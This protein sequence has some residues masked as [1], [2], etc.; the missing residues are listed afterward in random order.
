[1]TVQ[2][3]S[4]HAYFLPG[5]NLFPNWPESRSSEVSALLAVTLVVLLAPKLFGLGLALADRTIRT[6]FGGAGALLC[7]AAAELAF[8]VLLAPVMMYCHSRFVVEILLG[9]SVGWSTQPRDDRGIGLREAAARFALPTIFGLAWSAALL[10]VAP[11]YFVWFLPV[12]AGLVLSIPIAILSG[13][14]APGRAAARAGLFLTPE[15][16][17][18]PDL[19]RRLDAAL[20]HQPVLADAADVQRLTEALPA[21]SPQ[22]MPTQSL[23]PFWR[24]R[25]NVRIGGGR[26][27]AT[28]HA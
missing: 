24:N 3:L 1:V 19:L 8:S 2:A 20:R 16:V 26:P 4:E 18:R 6:A 27:A 7:G 9:R 21:P 11:A 28:L 14:V 25:R 22:P 15:E 17:D 13:R 5:Y 12:L 23:A 10:A